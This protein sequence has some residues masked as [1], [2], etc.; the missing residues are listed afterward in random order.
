MVASPMWMLESVKQTFA[1]SNS[2][3]RCTQIGMGSTENTNSK[4][5]VP[6]YQHRM[7]FYHEVLGRE[8][9][10]IIKRRKLGSGR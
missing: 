4:T 5:V 6:I 3:K 9:S 1:K 7:E 2:S 10:L 8:Y